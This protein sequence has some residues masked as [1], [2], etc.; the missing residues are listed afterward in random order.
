MK[1]AKYCKTVRNQNF[2]AK[3]EKIKKFVVLT[4]ILFNQAVAQEILPNDLAA[5]YAAHMKHL[6][7]LSHKNPRYPFAALILDNTTGKVLCEG[8][9]DSAKN[10]T[11]H[12]EIVAI[13]HCAAKFPKLNWQSTTLITTAEPCPMCESAIIWANIS[14]V[15]Y[16]TS[17]ET[18]KKYGWNQINISSVEVIKKSAFYH[19]KVVGGVLRDETDKLFVKGS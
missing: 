9:N 17:I 11:F 16:G 6:I 4:A 19:G 7:Q 3:K 15:V 10:P 13:N 8:V 1:Y 12:G 2:F 5:T 18:L 14:K